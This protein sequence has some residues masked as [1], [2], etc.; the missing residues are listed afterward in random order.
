[1]SSRSEPCS[2]FGSSLARLIKYE[3]WIATGAI[4]AW[5]R[6]AANRCSAGA[7]IAPT[8]YVFGL[9]LKN[10]SDVQPCFRA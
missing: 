5:A 1:M 7:S 3:V 9:P 4:P 8:R 2:V 6:A 10:C